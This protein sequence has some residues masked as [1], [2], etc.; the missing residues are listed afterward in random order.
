MKPTVF[1]DM[2]GVLTHHLEMFF[3]MTPERL[4]QEVDVN[5]IH[6]A[7]AQMF[8][9]FVNDNDLQ[10]VLSSDWRK[11]ELYR[12]SPQVFE[13]FF[14]KSTGCRIPVVGFTPK[15]GYRGMDILAYVEKHGI[16]N[17][18]ILDDCEDILPDQ[19]Q[20]FVHVNHLNGLT[21]SDLVIASNMLHLDNEVSKMCKWVKWHHAYKYYRPNNAG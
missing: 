1:L 7:K 9:N 13:D 3:E 2:D 21:M 12:N 4:D 10:V 20:R 15:M 5:Y 6:P 8:A 11:R 14:F 17:Y 16:E 19:M 18:V